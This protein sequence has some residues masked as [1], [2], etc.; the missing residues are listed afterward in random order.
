MPKWRR[1]FFRSV[2]TFWSLENMKFLF[3]LCTLCALSWPSAARDVTIDLQSPEWLPKAR[4]AIEQ[5]N[6]GLAINVLTQANEKQ[7]ADWH[8]LMGYS[9]R[10]NSPPQLL[11]AEQHYQA[12]LEK[13]P[14][15]LGAL[16]YYGELL[17]MKNDLTGAQA[18]LKRLE[19]ACPA[20]CEELR[21]LQKDVADFKAKK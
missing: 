6:Y 15:H 14:V 18:M 19:L 3:T 21:D 11:R 4:E 20:G 16:E 5:K 8:N 7:S 12:A 17:L 13:D 10:L 9:L 2:V 1:F